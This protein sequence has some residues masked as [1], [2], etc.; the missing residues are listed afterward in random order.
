MTSARITPRIN[1]T[2]GH[3]QERFMASLASGQCER[4]DR[5]VGVTHS[6]VTTFSPLPQPILRTS[7]THATKFTALLDPRNRPS[8]CTKKRAILTASASVILWPMSPVVSVCHFT[9]KK[10]RMEAL[11]RKA[12]SITGSASSMFFVTRLIP[13]PSTTVST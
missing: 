5:A 11:Y 6:T 9:K 8:R 1:L 3:P 13:M 7:F 4:S 2:R 10:T 12:S